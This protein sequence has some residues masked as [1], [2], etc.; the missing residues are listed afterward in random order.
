MKTSYLPLKA[1][2]IIYCLILIAWTIYHGST[3]FPEYVD[4]LLAKPIIWTFPVFI[5]MFLKKIRFSSLNFSTPTSRVILISLISGILLVLLQIIPNSLKGPIHLKIGLGF[6][7]FILLIFS[8]LGTAV[9]EEIL[10]RGFLLQ[11]IRQRFSAFVS[12]T[13]TS[14]M[15]SII[16]IPILLLANHLISFDL[17][18]GMYVIFASGVIFGALFLYNKTLWSPIIA[19]FILDVLLSIF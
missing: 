17:I 14:L 13:L 15:F 12:V 2:L 9:S 16:H 3:S 6:Q 8:Y 5:V 19:H 4:E 10:F 11:Q 18:I 7:P 1:L